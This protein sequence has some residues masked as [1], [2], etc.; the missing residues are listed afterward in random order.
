MLFEG[1]KISG[2]ILKLEIGL[3]CVLDF[4]QFVFRG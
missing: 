4:E 1:A 3:V 2:R